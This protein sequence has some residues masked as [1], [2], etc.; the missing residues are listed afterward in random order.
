MGD[1]ISVEDFLPNERDP[2]LMVAINAKGGNYT[3]DIYAGWWRGSE[4]ENSGENWARWPHDFEP[5][6]WQPLPPPPANA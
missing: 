2:I 4:I 5:T 1:W 6:H 3:T